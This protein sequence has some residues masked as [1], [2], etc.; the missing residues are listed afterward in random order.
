[1]AEA[2]QPTDAT[3][4]RSVAMGVSLLYSSANGRNFYFDD[5]VP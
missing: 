2:A 4:Q 1:M 5:F 3:Y